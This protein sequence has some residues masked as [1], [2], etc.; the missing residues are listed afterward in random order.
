MHMFIYLLLL[1]VSSI[2]SQSESEV[3]KALA[4]MSLC[5]KAASQNGQEPDPKIFSPM[6]LS[7]FMSIDDNQSKDILSKAQSGRI[8]EINVNTYKNLIDYNSLYTKHQKEELM[9]SSKKL[10]MAIEKFKKMRGQQMDGDDDDYEGG[11]RPSGAPSA[12]NVM[13]LFG[14]G[15][16]FVIAITNSFGGIIIIML[17][18]YF[19]LH[20]LASLYRAHVK[21]LKDKNKRFS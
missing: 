13:G 5:Q 12:Q 14:K 3:S 7:C 20:S 10:S 6:M 21:D 18:L 19:T 1:S 2:L 4:C 17:G 15:I 11:Y 8:N 16:A 9:E